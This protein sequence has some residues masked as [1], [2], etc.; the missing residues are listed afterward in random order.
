MNEQKPHPLKGKKK[1]AASIAKLKATLAAKKKLREQGLIEA[2][3]KKTRKPRGRIETRTFEQLK[4]DTDEAIF[5]L[6]RAIAG[7]RRKI[8]SGEIALTDVSDEETYMYMAIRYLH[9]GLK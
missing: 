7:T 4:R 2:P 1:S 8:K 9:G 5:C 3:A 6:E